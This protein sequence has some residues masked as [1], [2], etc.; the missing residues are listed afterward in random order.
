M[1][2]PREYRVYKPKN[3]GKGAASAWQLSFK[4]DNKYNPWMMFLVMAQQTGADDNGNA[5]FD[6]ENG[7]TVKLGD[8]DVGEI[9]AVLEGRKDSVGQ[10]GMLFHQTPSGGNKVIK[11]ERND[12]GYNLSVSAQD[13]NKNRLGPIYHSLTDGEATM[14]LVLLKQAIITMYGWF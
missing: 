10:K 13:E 14:L 1:N 11:L 2:K 8:A 5:R 4:Q 7:L 9:I 6:W 12:Y 3:D